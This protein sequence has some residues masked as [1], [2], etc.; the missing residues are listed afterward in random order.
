LIEK[1][2]ELLIC[3]DAYWKIAGDECQLGEPW[4]PDWTDNYQKKWIINFYQG[5]I[6]LTSGTNVN[7]VLAFPEKEMRDAFYE[8]FKE[9]IEQCKELL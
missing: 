4:I 2:Q 1:L 3:R 6:N 5:E 8:N 7:F 9:L